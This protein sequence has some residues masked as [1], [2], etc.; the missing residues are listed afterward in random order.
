M[1]GRLHSFREGLAVSFRE[2]NMSCSIPLAP[3]ISCLDI[4]DTV[5]GRNPANQLIVYPSI[6][7]VLAPSQV[8]SRISSI[9]STSICSMYATCPC[10]T[11]VVWL[12]F[13]Q[14]R[15]SVNKPTHWAQL[16]YVFSEA[17]TG[18]KICPSI[19]EWESMP[20]Q[21]IHV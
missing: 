11:F 1:V 20:I 18:S 12:L 13:L 14:P 2:G 4:S 10:C 19:K 15:T 3:R 8:V 17:L 9:N 6:Y 16:G 5:D 21:P 7:K